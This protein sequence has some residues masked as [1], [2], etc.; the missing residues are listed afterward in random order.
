[1][2]FL[3]WQIEILLYTTKDWIHWVDIGVV[4]LENLM[5]N[6]RTGREPKHW[7]W[8]S[9]SWSVTYVDDDQMLAINWKQTQQFWSS[10]KVPT[11][12][13]VKHIM[14]LHTTVFVGRV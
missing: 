10:N 11:Q 9:Q 1:M 12:Q 7:V 2:K 13:E 6:R 5:T 4:Q 3:Q 8:K 14:S